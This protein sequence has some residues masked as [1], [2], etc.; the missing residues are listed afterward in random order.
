MIRLYERKVIDSKI[1]FSG[2]IDPT[3]Y[4]LSDAIINFIIDNGIHISAHSRSN[5]IK[6]VTRDIK[7]YDIPIPIDIFIND[8]K[9]PLSLADYNTFTFAIESDGE[10]LLFSDSPE[11]ISIKSANTLL[12]F[13]FGKVQISP[14]LKKTRFLLT[15]F[16]ILKGGITNE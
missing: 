15:Q 14:T 8:N 12:E 7:T 3:K 4:I 9:H 16:N 5:L 13:T 10:M 1:N 11:D 2:E 6:I